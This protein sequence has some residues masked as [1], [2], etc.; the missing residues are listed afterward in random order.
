MEATLAWTIPK[1]RRS[2]GG[3]PGDNIILDQL[4]NGAQKKRVGFLSKGP[5]VRGEANIVDAEGNTIGKTTSGCPSPCL[6]KGFNISMGYIDKKVSKLGTEVN[7]IVRNK[8][9]K[10][11]ITK[12][13]F[14]K[15]NYYFV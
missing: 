6:G 3:F 8:P 14:V 15:T 4:K 7:I 5:P 11:T 12:M 1:S 10:A 13:P 9:V 2:T